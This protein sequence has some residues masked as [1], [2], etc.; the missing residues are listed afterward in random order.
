MSALIRAFALLVGALISTTTLASSPMPGVPSGAASA[1][2]S[3]DIRDIRGPISI[4][5]W[6]R[7]LAMAAGGLAIVGS[8]ATVLVALR[9]RR[10]RPLEPYEL[11]LKRLDEAQPLADEGLARAY[12]LSAS[13]TLREYIE[14]RFGLRAAH[15][16]TEELFADLVSHDTGPLG[17][18]RK[19]LTEFLEACDL[20]KFARL[21]LPPAALATMNERAR[22]FVLATMPTKVGTQCA[23]PRTP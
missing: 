13:D 18:H 23:P 1:S 12:A 6:W 14:M 11:A 4:A 20:A 19:S 7:W 10:A 9:R 16:T 2:A 17:E 3:E 22:N 8:A 21:A 15:A 5:P